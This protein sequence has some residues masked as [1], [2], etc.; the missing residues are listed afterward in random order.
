MGMLIMNISYATRHN[1]MEEMLAIKNKGITVVTR[2]KIN[3][4]R[5]I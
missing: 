4:E 3:N 1:G 5:K 2:K